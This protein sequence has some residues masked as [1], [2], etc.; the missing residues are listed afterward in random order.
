MGSARFGSGLLSCSSI[1]VVTEQSVV[2]SI[3]RTGDQMSWDRIAESVK[4]FSPNQRR[5]RSP[6]CRGSSK[7]DASLVLAWFWESVGRGQCGLWVAGGSL[8]STGS[9]QDMIST[10]NQ[11]CNNYTRIGYVQVAGA[12]L[13]LVV[14][15]GVKLKSLLLCAL[16]RCMVLL[17]L[18]LPL[19]SLFRIHAD[20][21]ATPAE[22]KTMKT[23]TTTKER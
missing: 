1:N 21:R 12:P 4:L 23:S 2:G 15:F 5:T 14:C 3:L 8:D 7:R 10:L 17:Q 11:V 6:A 9:R 13:A 18:Q 16:Q 20:I 19:Q 22:T